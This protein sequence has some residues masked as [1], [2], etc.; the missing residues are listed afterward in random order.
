[1]CFMDSWLKE[2]ISK[3][4]WISMCWQIHWRGQDGYE[5][6]RYVY[7]TIQI[8]CKALKNAQRKKQVKCCEKLANFIL[9]INFLSHLTR[10]EKESL[11]YALKCLKMQKRII[12]LELPRC[13]NAAQHKQFIY[14][15]KKNELYVVCQFMEFF[16]YLNSPFN[17]Y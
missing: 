6:S 9:K 16:F 10:F 14:N 12:T 2:Y 17:W 15:Q 3:S 4:K 13:K 8:E 7:E 5:K 11:K 1:M